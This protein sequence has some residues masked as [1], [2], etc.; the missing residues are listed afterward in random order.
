MQPRLKKPR[1]STLGIIGFGAFGKLAAKAL[2]GHFETL[3]YDALQV[4]EELA[5]SMGVKCVPL[6]VAA[7]CDIV[8]IATPVGVL[9]EIVARISPFL[10]PGAYVLDVGSVKLEP[11]RIMAS[12][13]PDN[14]H[15]IATHPLFGPQSAVD[16]VSGHKIAVC[17]LRGDRYSAAAFMRKALGL[18]VF[19]VSPAEHDRELATVQGLTHFIARVL[20][21]MEPLPGRMTTRSFDHIMAAVEMVRHD[22]PEVWEAIETANPFAAGV[23]DRFV[24]LT[25]SLTREL[26]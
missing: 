7:A 13:L 15:V 11:A 8:V 22:A 3:V 10:K 9:A 25:K 19:I 6:P 4:D 24:A 18:R 16:S 5:A 2:A 14:V 1:A 23:R 20:V 17:P 12:M 21:Q 26:E